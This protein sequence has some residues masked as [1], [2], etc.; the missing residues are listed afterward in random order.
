[1]GLPAW[2]YGSKEDSE[3]EDRGPY[4]VN[5]KTGQKIPKGASGGLTNLTKPGDLPPEELQRRLDAWEAETAERQARGE[6]ET[7]LGPGGG[8][9]P[10]A[11]RFGDVVQAAGIDPD[12]PDDPVATAFRDRM[13]RSQ[14]VPDRSN[15]ENRLHDLERWTASM[16]PRLPESVRDQRLAR[17]PE[18]G[19]PHGWTDT[20]DPKWVNPDGSIRADA[21]D[22]VHRGIDESAELAELQ[23]ER[24]LIDDEYEP[25]K[26]PLVLRKR[27]P[28]G[29][30]TYVHAL[31]GRPLFDLGE[32]GLNDP[33]GGSKVD[34]YWREGRREW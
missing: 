18:G 32:Y 4:L 22:E 21:P 6:Y 31:T 12:D 7:T 2:V 23:A 17:G 10:S 20:Y 28:N 15:V 30:V 24:D 5:R 16:P 9:G 29:T 27:H 33:Q 14:G 25:T 13:I 26:S 3:W 8:L 19:R 34:P 1:M 11:R